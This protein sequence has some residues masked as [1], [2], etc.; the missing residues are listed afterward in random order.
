MKVALI[1]AGAVGAYFIWGFDGNPDI[2]LTLVAKGQRLDKLRKTGV[3]I[4]SKTYFP[5]VKCAEDAG[6]Q[7]LILVATKYNGLDEAIELLP[8]MIGQN[9]VV[10]SLLNGVDSEER[11]AAR[12]GWE[13]VEYSLMRIASRRTE[14][15]ITFDPDNTQGL[16]VGNEKLSKQIK[17]IIQKS[18]IVCTF[19]D[20][21]IQDIWIKYASNIANN[22]PQA[23]LG[24]DASLYTDSE[25]GYFIAARLWDEVYQVAKAKGIDVGVTPGIFRRVAKTSKY[26]TLQDLEAKRHTEIDMFAGKLMAMAKELN[27]AVPYTEYTYHA[28]KALEE[29]ND[30]LISPVMGSKSLEAQSSLAFWNDIHEKKANNEVVMD[31][32]LEG[33]EDIID[34]CELPI[35]DLGCGNGNDTMYLINKKKCVV[36]CDQ[37][38]IAIEGIKRRF[39]DVEQAICMNML[40]GFEMRDNYFGIVIADLSLHYFK[41]AD[42][43]KILREIKRIL[44]PGGHLLVR[45]NSINDVKH[46][47]GKGEEIEHHLYK[48]D[49]GML[50]RFF[51]KL[52]VESIFA[53]FEI[54]FYEEKKML[55]YKEE[56][57]LYVVKLRKNKIGIYL[58]EKREG[59]DDE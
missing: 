26:S 48:T 46:G 22:L 4:N 29:K 36:A 35:L 2:E 23:V 56:K 32:W 3:R 9:T 31:G 51:D 20:N 28:I 16:F 7:D 53:D 41:K 12:I 33:F 34:A 18:R 1:G 38:E 27:I 39:P 8:V 50:K 5:V 17:D 37:S 42:T 49:N 57:Y 40:D 6:E 19:E 15:G 24:T 44:V 43:D 13:H 21:I 47:A 54:E 30:G 45:V 59:I 11:V 58:N 14:S 52:D 55:R 10:L 25:H